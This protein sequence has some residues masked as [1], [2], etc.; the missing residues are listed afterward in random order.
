MGIPAHPLLVHAP[1]VFVPLLILVGIGYALVPPLR[2][3]LGWV[4]IVLAI[5]APGAAF[6][7]K[8]SGDAFRAR[9]VRNGTATPEVLTDIDQHRGFGTNLVYAALALAVVVVVLVLLTRPSAN[10]DSPKRSFTPVAII[11]TILVL[12]AG[13][14]SGYYVFKAGDSGAKMVWSGL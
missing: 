10:P 4:A 6:L 14:T 3:Y 7:A 9:L 11:L 8:L 5:A 13:G 2:R 12:A 1:V